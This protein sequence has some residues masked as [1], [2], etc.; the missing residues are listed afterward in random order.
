MIATTYAALRELVADALP[1]VEVPSS[2]GARWIAPAAVIAPA[3]D[4]ITSSTV[5]AGARTVRW[6]IVLV[7]GRVDMDAAL[8][9]LSELVDVLTAA[10]DRDRSWSG[11]EWSGPAALTAGGVDYLSTEATVE[12]LATP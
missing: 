12:T 6:R 10:L 5:V 7:S 4:W 8:E 3:A 2:P 1:G 11:P 9:E